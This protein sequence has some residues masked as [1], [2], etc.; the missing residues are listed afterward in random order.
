[1]GRMM[2]ERRDDFGLGQTIGEFRQC[3]KTIESAIALIAENQRELQREMWMA[4]GKAAV[5]GFLG[6]TIATIAIQLFLRYV[7]KA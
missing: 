3:I 1:M 7:V 5:Y 6:A 4:K 2:A